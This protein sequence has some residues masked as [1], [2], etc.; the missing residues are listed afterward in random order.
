MERA[1]GRFERSIP[2]PSNVDA[3]RSEVSDQGGVI[4][5]ILPKIEAVP[6]TMSILFRTPILLLSGL[7]HASIDEIVRNKTKPGTE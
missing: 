3:A 4:T 6:P 5:V 7:R 1:F 2:L